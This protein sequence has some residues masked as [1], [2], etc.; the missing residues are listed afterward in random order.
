MHQPNFETFSPD[1]FLCGAFFELPCE[2]L[3]SLSFGVEEINCLKVI[4]ELSNGHTF[5]QQHKHR[6]L[7]I[8][9]MRQFDSY[10]LEIINAKKRFSFVTLHRIDL[11]S[12]NFF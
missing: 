9:Q 5:L 8:V 12:Y 3:V 10:Q 7:V 4:F 2:K 6:R 11:F 1:F